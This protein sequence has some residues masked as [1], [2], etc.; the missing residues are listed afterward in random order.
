MKQWLIMSWNWLIFMTYRYQPAI[1]CWNIQIVFAWNAP[2]GLE[3]V[4]CHQRALQ[5]FQHYFLPNW[6]GR[7]MYRDIFWRFLSKIPFLVRGKP[8]F[9][10][11]FKGNFNLITIH[12]RMIW[13]D[14]E[15]LEFQRIYSPQSR[16]LQNIK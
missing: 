15:I 12:H 10:K 8:L 16:I 14:G 9:E 5:C 6:R 1:E 7:E 3:C 11:V 2:S 4:R 13:T